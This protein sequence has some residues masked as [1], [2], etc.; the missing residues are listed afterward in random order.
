[1]LVV[2]DSLEVVRRDEVMEGGVVDGE[3]DGVADGRGAADKVV[4]TVDSS[5]LV[6]DNMAVAGAVALAADS[7]VVVV[8]A[9]DRMVEVV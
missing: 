7:M 3:V 5:M 4:D 9:G 1:M 8:A 6:A 2:E